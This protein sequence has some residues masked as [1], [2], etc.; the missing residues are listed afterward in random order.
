MPDQSVIPIHK[1]DHTEEVFFVKSGIEKFIT[2]NDTILVKEGNTIYIPPEH[3]HG[4]ENDGDL[5]YLV[6]V[7]TP[8]GLDNFFRESNSNK[9]LIPEQMDE[10]ARKHDQVMKK[11]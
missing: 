4:L 2:E 5:L 9:T 1:H 3:W 8:P 11:N 10:I 7:V 6:F